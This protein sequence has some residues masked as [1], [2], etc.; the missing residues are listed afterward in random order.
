MKSQLAN[1]DWK[2]KL[3]DL[4][5]NAA[6]EVFRTEY[7]QYKQA[8]DKHVPLKQVNTNKKPLWMK[9]GVKKSVMKKHHL[10]MKYRWTMR[11]K[12]YL[13]YV[14]QRNITKKAVVKTQAD[15]EKTIMKEFKDKP[16]QLFNYVREKKKVKSGISRLENEKGNLTEDEKRLPMS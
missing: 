8:V 5:C 12:D 11:Y 14:K 15:F 6:W 7:K 16:E 9:A 3:D 1:T 10:H 2:G 4:S 13:E